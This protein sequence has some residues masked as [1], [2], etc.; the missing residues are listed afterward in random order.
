MGRTS[1]PTMK[2][3]S[4]GWGRTPVPASGFRGLVR[5]T[6]L[7]N[8][9][10]ILSALAIAASL[11]RPAAFLI[12]VVF[13]PM[14]SIV[15]WAATFAVSAFVSLSRIFWEQGVRGRRPRSHTGV[16]DVGDEWL[17]GPA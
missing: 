11:G 4:E 3:V 9:G 2:S 7:L 10:I 6:A 17:D 15:L 1:S 5:K 14:I 13:V 16:G 12:I 8:L